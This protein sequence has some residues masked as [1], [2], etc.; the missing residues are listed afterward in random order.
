[1][2]IFESVLVTLVTNI[3]V[4]ASCTFLTRIEG[5]LGLNLG[6]LP[7]GYA[8]GGGGLFPRVKQ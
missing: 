3:Y 4:Y 8:G 1:V 6:P 5:V 7:I 2:D